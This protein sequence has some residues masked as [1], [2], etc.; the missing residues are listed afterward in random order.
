MRSFVLAASL[1]Y[2]A[3]I[4]AQAPERPAFEIASITP[5]K[6]LERGGRLRFLP[7][8]RF[9]G[10]NIYVLAL[11][12]SAFGDEQPLL[13]SRITGGPE[14]HAGSGCAPR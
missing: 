14:L 5:H 2:G 4:A 13:P 6:T 7:G 12:A 10:F 1:A 9:Q 11:I 3:T 8:G